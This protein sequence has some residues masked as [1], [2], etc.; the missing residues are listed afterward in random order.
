[1]RV[2]PLQAGACWTPR[3]AA[4]DAN[5]FAQES[6]GEVCHG[7]YGRS[8]HRIVQKRSKHPSSLPWPSRLTPISVCLSVCLS[9]CCSGGQNWQEF[10]W[11]TSEHSSRCSKIERVLSFILY[12][13]ISQKPLL[14]VGDGTLSNL[15]T[16]PCHGTL[17]VQKWL[18]TKAMLNLRNTSKNGFLS[19]ISFFTSSLGSQNL[20]VS[21]KRRSSLQP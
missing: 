13:S 11:S 1:M 21:C 10:P 18:I 6:K 14:I 5:G 4:H 20:R 7:G 9:V 3:S 19:F 17:L 12:G 2:P 15:M 16:T 8:N